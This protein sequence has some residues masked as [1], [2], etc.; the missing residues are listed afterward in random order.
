MKHSNQEINNQKTTN[1]VRSSTFLQK[2]IDSIEIFKL[3]VFEIQAELAAGY[4]F[5][6]IIFGKKKV[7][8]QKNESCKDSIFE[9]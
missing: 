7:V 8:K 3:K 6:E 9:Q 5:K 4:T 2:M 1:S